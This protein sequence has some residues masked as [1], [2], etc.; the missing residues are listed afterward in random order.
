MWQFISHLRLKNGCDS[1]IREIVYNGLTE[2]GIP[3]KLA[4]L[5]KTCK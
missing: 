5:I 3:T 1:G 4:P 2:S